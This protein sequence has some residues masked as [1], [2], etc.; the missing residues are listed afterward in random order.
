MLAT[1]PY[2]YNLKFDIFDA[3]VLSATL[4]C[5]YCVLGDFHM[6]TDTL[7]QNVLLVFLFLPLLHWD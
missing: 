5:L 6:S 1:C 3:V 7:V 4:S 2:F